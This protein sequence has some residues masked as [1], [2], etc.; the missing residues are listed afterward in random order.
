[1]TERWVSPVEH[2]RTRPVVSG[3]LLEMTGCKTPASGALCETLSFLYNVLVAPSNCPH[4]MG[5][6]SA[7]GVLNPCSQVLNTK[8]IVFRLHFFIDLIHINSNFFSFTN[9]P[10]PPSVHHHVYVC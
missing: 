6:H 4:S 5:G 7:T 9:V 10:T 3:G 8:C 1:M 2:D